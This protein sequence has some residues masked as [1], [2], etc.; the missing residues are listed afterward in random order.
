MRIY[1]SNRV[2]SL[3]PALARIVHSPVS[4]PFA[5]EWIVVQGPGME[6]WLS[7]ALSR[8][9]GVFA[10]P[11]F[12]FPRTFLSEMIDAVLGPEE[13][14]T[15]RYEPERLAWTVAAALPEHLDKPAFA[16]LAQYLVGDE[17]GE[18]GLQLA[19]R[20]AETFDHYVMHRPEMILGW[21]AGSGQSRSGQLDAELDWQRQ[22]WRSLVKRCGPGHLASRILGLIQ[23]LDASEATGFELPERISIFGVSTLPPLFVEGLTALSK[24]VP[25]HLFVLSPSQ[26]Y[27]GHIR[28][29]REQIRQRG[30][31]LDEADLHFEQ[32]HPL[33]ASLGRVGR[34][35]QE[36][37][38]SR[39]EYL[40]A[41]EDLYQDPGESSMLCAIQ[42]D[43]LMLRDPNEDTDPGAGLREVDAADDSI[44]VH[45]CHGPMREAEVLRDRLIELFERDSSLQARDVVI[46]TPNV[47]RYAPFVEAAFSAAG[48]GSLPIQVADASARSSSELFDAFSR[49]LDVLHGRMRASEVV[50]LLSTACIREKFGL[51]EDDESRIRAW[52]RSSGIRWGVD[53]AH[54][55]AEGQPAVGQN[56]WRFGFD[57]LLLGYA[58]E[59]DGR[60]VFG[61]VRP[62]QA[63]SGMESESLGRV[64]ELVDTLGELHHQARGI[65]EVAEWAVFMTQVL[66]ATIESDSET[67]HQ[68]R[69]IRE[70]IESWA[71]SAQ[72]ADYPEPLSFQAVLESFSSRMEDRRAGGGFL[73]GAIT[74]CELVPMRTIPF[75]VVCLMGMDDGAFPR[76]GR[77]VSFDLLGR[78]RKLGDRSRRDDDRYLFLEA[79]LSARDHLLVTYTGSNWRD[80]QDLPPSVVIDELLEHLGSAFIFPGAEEGGASRAA[81]DHLRFR[82]P[83]QSFSP[84]YFTDEDPRFF[85]YSDSDCRAARALLSPRLKPSPFASE[86]LPSLSSESVEYTVDDLVDFFRNPARHFSRNRLGLWLPNDEDE[87][88]VDREPMDVAG[89]DEWKVGSAVLEG[90]L[91]GTPDEVV[92]EAVRGQ[93]DLPLG[94]AGDSAYATISGTSHRLFDRALRIREGE[95]HAPLEID[96]ELAGVRV[97][98][99]IDQLWPSGRVDLR[100]SRLGGTSELEN[101]IKHLVLCVEAPKGMAPTTHLLGRPEDGAGLGHV[102][103][104]EVAEAASLLADLVALRRYGDCLPLPFFPKSSRKYVTSLKGSDEPHRERQARLNAYELFRSRKEEAIGESVRERI[105]TWLVSSPRK[106]RWLLRG[107]VRMVT[108]PSPLRFLRVASSSLCSPIGRCFSDGKPGSPQCA[109]RR[110][111]TRGSE[112]RYGQDLYADDS[113][114]AHHHGRGL[115]SGSDPGGHLYEGRGGRITRADS[116]APS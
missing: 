8:E 31:S 54:R 15:L 62:K 70:A 33:L 94:Q 50:D 55:E 32:G 7:M 49:V 89:L 60:R 34:E 105:Y 16:P 69:Q 97:V 2:E 81:H 25:V 90:L 52:V 10:N 47:D 39:T 107:S 110:D 43:I 6:K 44:S 103:F 22:L 88:S 9:N 95:S 35:F 42:S 20:I 84:R 104:S 101:W 1:R 111:P 74:L 27:W 40:E 85:S 11:R 4:D 92:A 72:E 38:E 12:P 91:S 76:T 93:G 80:N 17:N 36:I 18:K 24:R 102:C 23:T 53:P 86:A 66:D 51:L 77:R 106:T 13:D 67:L 64:I 116:G 5:P 109:A 48:S 45:A 58:M 37:L 26:Q 108:R 115:R 78:E 96:L 57:R 83:L 65:R 29:E 79:L 56:T 3:V 41:D 100:Y 61:S 82:H 113:L 30:S 71:E 112:C 59:D 28:S 14:D 46:M 63:V 75:R 21:E 114:F 87:M 99:E 68:H 73:S 98:G 19:R